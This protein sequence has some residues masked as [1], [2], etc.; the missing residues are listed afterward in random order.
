M[1]LAWIALLALVLLTTN[2]SVAT[3][4]HRSQ[5]LPT[6]PPDTCVT[7]PGDD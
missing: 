5:Y 1:R 3:H 7:D 4:G 2:C 6:A